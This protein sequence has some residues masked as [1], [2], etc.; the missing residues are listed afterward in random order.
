VQRSSRKRLV[1]VIALVGVILIA[2]GIMALRELMVVGKA[3]SERLARQVAYT[4]ISL[5]VGFWC[6][7]W[8]LVAG[9]AWA[10]RGQTETSAGETRSSGKA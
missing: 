9:V 10:R 5:A 6:I 3:P 7:V 4:I 8:W 1:G 2:L